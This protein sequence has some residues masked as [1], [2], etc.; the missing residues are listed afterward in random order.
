MQAYRTPWPARQYQFEADTSRE[1]SAHS[2]PNFRDLPSLPTSNCHPK[3]PT[4]FRLAPVLQR[5]GHRL[6]RDLPPTRRGSFFRDRHASPR[7]G[8]PDK[9]GPAPLVPVRHLLGQRRDNPLQTP[10]YKLGT[11]HTW[12]DAEL[13]AYEKRWPLGTRQRLAYDVL[14]YSAQRVARCGTDAAI[15]Y[16]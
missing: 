9:G 10:K 2:P 8:E 16:P 12:T 4:G 6:V 15:G 14:L 13:E 7:H 1:R 11:H 5:D 3:R